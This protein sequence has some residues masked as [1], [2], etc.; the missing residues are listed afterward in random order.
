M[1][2]VLL[3]L[4]AAVLLFTVTACNPQ[5]QPEESVTSESIS[6][7]TFVYEKEGAGG[8]F[9]I[10]IHEDGTFFYS[11]GT[12]SSYIG[13]GAWTLEGDTLTLTDDE[14]VSYGLVNRFKVVGGDLI[15]FSEGST[16]FLYVK[17]ADG[18]KFFAK[19]EKA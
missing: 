18:E 6:G 2:R 9:S 10:R 15:Y 16:N 19:Q 7:I 14:N 1:K 13:V 8:D 5:E 11:E 4:C 3:L 12:Y 17:A